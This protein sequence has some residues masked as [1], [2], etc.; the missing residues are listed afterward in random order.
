MSV[1]YS[2]LFAMNC[3]LFR[4]R[5]WTSIIIIKLTSIKKKSHLLEETRGHEIYSW[6]ITI[7]SYI[8]IRNIVH[9]KLDKNFIQLKYVT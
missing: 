6:K 1:Y 3:G 7:I 8:V 4:V 2:R 5:S 9:A